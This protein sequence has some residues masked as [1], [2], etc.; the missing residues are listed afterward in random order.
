MTALTAILRIRAPHLRELRNARRLAVALLGA[1]AAFAALFAFGEMYLQLFPPSDIGQYLGDRAPGIG[2]YRSDAKLGADY[3]DFDA[4]ASENRDR[5]SAFLPLDKAAASKPV[6]AFFGNSFVQMTGMLGDA[7]QI[8]LTDR[9]ILYLGRNEPLHLRAAQ[10]RL[11]LDNGLKPSRVIFA[12]MPLDTWP[13]SQHSLDDIVVNGRGVVTY[14][15]PIPATLKQTGSRLALSAWLRLVQPLPST[16]TYTR[17]LY[18][19]VPDELLVQT[20]RMFDVLADSCR[21]H[22][23]KG[24][25]LLIP[26]HEQITRAFPHDFQ[27]RMGE[28]CRARGLDVCDAIG[29]FAGVADKASLFIPDKHFSPPGNAI[30]LASLLDHL[31]RSEP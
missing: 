11:L 6:W 19:Q 22:G 18:S 10:I 23:V 5:L 20:G 31:G 16:A 21:R 17:A 2:I 8:A 9:R 3:R 30:L 29:A 27:D 25:V 12:L 7:A 28:Q 13:Y 24:T 26:S 14:R 15:P 1:I 4:F